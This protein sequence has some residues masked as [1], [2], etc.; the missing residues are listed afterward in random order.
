[1]LCLAAALLL[2]GT[3][4]GCAAP[5]SAGVGDAEARAQAATCQSML[6]RRGEGPVA[7]IDP[8]IFRA[9]MNDPRL[10]G[11]STAAVLVQV[12]NTIARKRAEAPNS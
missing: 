11:R 3:L 4:A 6:E 7:P 10:A 1:M 9:A 8:A 2:G 5:G 12:C